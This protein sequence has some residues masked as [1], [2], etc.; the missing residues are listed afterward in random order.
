MIASNV[1]CKVTS[2]ND[3]KQRLGPYAP[4]LAIL[5]HYFKKRLGVVNGFVA[6]GAPV[7]TSAGPFL[8]KYL[9]EA[10]GV[11][12]LVSML[13]AVLMTFKF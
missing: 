7:L 13:K 9:A 5:V 4:S 8:P 1:V 3:S 6:C 12:T 2:M 10:Y 11:S